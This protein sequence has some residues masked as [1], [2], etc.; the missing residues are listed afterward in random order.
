MVPQGNRSAED[1]DMPGFHEG[2]PP[3][4]TFK[5]GAKK[6]LRVPLLKIQIE[7]FEDVG[8]MISPHG[9]QP[10]DLSRTGVNRSKTIPAHDS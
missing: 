1:L 7:A 2:A 9:N 4:E 8:S 6:S 3:A 10:P 5:M